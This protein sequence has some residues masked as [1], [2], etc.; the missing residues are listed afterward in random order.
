MGAEASWSKAPRHCQVAHSTTGQRY[1]SHTVIARTLIPRGRSLNDAVSDVEGATE[2]VSLPEEVNS[3]ANLRR[4]LVKTGSEPVRP[5]SNHFPIFRRTM[6]ELAVKPEATGRL[7][8]GLVTM[9]QQTNDERRLWLRLG[10]M[11]PAQPTRQGN[12]AV[13][14]GS[15]WMQAL[16]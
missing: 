8:V 4:L 6:P 12:N 15:V 1:V 14:I 5:L 9:D 3:G 16:D 10:R 7:E 13:Q 2:W 11:G